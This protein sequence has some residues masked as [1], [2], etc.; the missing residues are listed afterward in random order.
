[1][2]DFEIE[3]KIQTERVTEKVIIIV[4]GETIAETDYA[5]KVT[6][7][8]RDPVIYVPKNDIKEVDLIKC[9]DYQDPYKGHAEIYTI[10]HGAHDIENAAW[11]YDEP[12]RH[13]PEL[14][15]KVAFYEDKVQ[16]IRI[17]EGYA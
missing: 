14:M 13:Y 3:H 11:C 6:E 8:G 4:E 7:T 17:G 5:L 15:G 16:E 12:V 10:R 9:G 2:D 1:M